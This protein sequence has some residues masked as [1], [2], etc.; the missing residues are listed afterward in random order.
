[1][2]LPGLQQRLLD[3]HTALR[4]AGVPVAL[5]DGMDAMRAAAAVDLLDRAVL[6][7]ALAATLVSSPSHRA[8]FDALFDLYFPRT[9]GTP[10]GP[11]AAPP[12][13][14]DPVALAEELVERLIEGEEEEIRRMAR[15][16]VAGLGGVRGADGTTSYY[17]YRVW[18][19]LNLRGL[20]RRLVQ[21]AGI[22]GSDDLADRL[23]ADELAGRL[24]RFREEVEAEIRRLQAEAR[25]ADAVARRAVRTLPEQVDF[26]S[27]TAD[28]QAAMQRAVRPL[29][30]KL[31]TRLAARRRRAR[32]GALDVR[33]TLR[34]ALSTGGV[35]IDP[36]FRAK[37]TR[38]PELVLICDV[39]GSV[40]AFAKFTLLLTHALQ[41]QFSRVRSFAFVD[42]VDE[43]TDLFAD[44]DLATGMA[45][46]A[47]EADLVR[48]DGHSDYGHAF[49]TFAR[50]H[51][52]ALTP[53]TTVLVLG[54]ARNNYR[55][56]GTPALR[57]IR[58][59][60]RRLLWLNPE[61]RGQ[62]DAGDS[63][64]STYAAVC[65]RMVEC[66]N[67][68]QLAAFVETLG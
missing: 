20:F 17:A 9:L 4:D 7:E 48:L 55:A 51:R 49:D 65:E 47:A 54:D 33:R 42:T 68:A 10:G 11:A 36:A 35:P 59:R 29:A 28:E 32:H 23:L 43:V 15:E 50:R 16:A 22:E 3:L 66:R 24:Q 12:A 19:H 31:A 40:A 30:R 57:D 34:R 38:R 45:R 46:M 6:R 63:L 25:G 52:D 64:A 21:D 1:V 53:R 67:L 39:S 56:A 5:S 58:D 18:R 41:G 8:A 13:D 62:W 37:R 60:S 2:P 44:G 61:P 14:V 26:F 27:V